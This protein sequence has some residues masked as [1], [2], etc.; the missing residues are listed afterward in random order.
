MLKTT[1]N[2]LIWVRAG[3]SGE[4]QETAENT[5]CEKQKV[6]LHGGHV[7]RL[8][9]YL[10]FS[11]S[12]SICTNTWVILQQID[13]LLQVIPQNAQT[14]DKELPITEN[15]EQAPKERVSNRNAQCTCA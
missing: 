13:L 1:Q 3:S 15:I 7:S 4:M 12:I 2:F 8:N 14:F 9:A 10:A 6:A 5:Q 11:G